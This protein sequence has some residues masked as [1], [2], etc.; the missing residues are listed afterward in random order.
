MDSDEFRNAYLR[1]FL[2]TPQE[3]ILIEENKR[4]KADLYALQ[5]KYNRVLNDLQNSIDSV[6]RIAREGKSET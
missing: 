1:A 3:Q 2:Q 5:T 4:L 6:L